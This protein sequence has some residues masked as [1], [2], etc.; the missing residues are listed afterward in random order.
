[1]KALSEPVFAGPK[2]ELNRMV[3]SLDSFM[4]ETFLKVA[5]G[6]V[7]KIESSDNESTDKLN[8]DYECLLIQCNHHQ[9]GA[10][11][12]KSRFNNMLQLRV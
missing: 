11:A 2:E 7:L 12:A 6:D 1:M 9:G 5:K 8:E 3:S 10:Q 4:R